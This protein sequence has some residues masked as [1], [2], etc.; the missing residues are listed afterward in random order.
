M[1]H[2]R[3]L[4]PRQWQWRLPQVRA[5]LQWRQRQLPQGRGRAPWR[6]LWELQL[7]RQLGWQL[8][9]SLGRLR[10]Q[11]VSRDWPRCI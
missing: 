6:L 9:P 11:E 4:H 7:G 8:E 2:E 5:F 10:R 1:T 3:A